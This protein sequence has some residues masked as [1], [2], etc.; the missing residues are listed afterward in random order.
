MVEQRVLLDMRLGA[1]L[2][3]SNEPFNASTRRKLSSRP[4]TGAPAKLADRNECT[5]LRIA[6]R[7]AE[8]TY[9]MFQQ[10]AGVNIFS[11]HHI[12]L[13]KEY[14]IPNWIAKKRPKLEVE[15]KNASLCSNSILEI[16]S[17]IRVQLSL[18]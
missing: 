1:M 11:W 6:R 3:R 5:N 15:E 14:R 13:Y 7:I 16:T 12:P 10:Q 9:Y 18:Q 8:I 2:A 4:R 17:P